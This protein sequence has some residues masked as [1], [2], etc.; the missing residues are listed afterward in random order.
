MIDVTLFPLLPTVPGVP[1]PRCTVVNT[2]L[3][4]AKSCMQK[5]R[6]SS[7]SEF[8]PKL[9]STACANGAPKPRCRSAQPQAVGSARNPP[10]RRVSNRSMKGSESIK[11]QSYLISVMTVL[12]QLFRTITSTR[13]REPAGAVFERFLI[14]ERPKPL[15]YY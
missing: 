1:A 11:R 5:A 12:S 2:L 6:S 4:I 15:L 8:G 3:L 14:F 7:I 10:E 13:Y 9:L